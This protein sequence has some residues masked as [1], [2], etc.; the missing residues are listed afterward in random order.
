MKNMR[1]TL[2]S[3]LLLVAVLLLSISCNRTPEIELPVDGS[4]L[5]IKGIIGNYGDQT[6]VGIIEDNPDYGTTGEQ[7][8]WVDGDQIKLLL[9]PGGNL[10]ATPIV[11]VFEAQ[12]SGGARSKNCSFTSV[13][14][15][16]TIPKGS[17]TVYSLYPAGGWVDNGDGTWTVSMPANNEFAKDSYT[18]ESEGAYM[19]KKADAG[20]VVIGDGD[21][22]ITLSFTPMAAVARFNIKPN[23]SRMTRFTKLTLTAS[24]QIFPTTATLPSISATSLTVGATKT[25]SLTVDIDNAFQNT[26]GIIDIFFPILPTGNL[27]SSVDFDIELIATNFLDPI[28]YGIPSVITKIPLLA[29]GFEASSSYYFNLRHTIWSRSNIVLDDPNSKLTFAEVSADNATIPANV[30]GVFFK[31]G[32]LLAISPASLDP[33][34]TLVYHRNYVAGDYPTGHVVYNPTS[35]SSYIW[36]DVPYIDEVSAAFPSN[37]NVNRDDFAAYNSNTGFDEAAGLGDICRYITSK[38]WVSGKWRLPTAHE[39]Y[40]LAGTVNVPNGE[41]TAVAHGITSPGT[42]AYGNN[43]FGYFQYSGGRW[44][45][46]KAVTTESETNPTVGVFFFPASGYRSDGIGQGVAAN[47]RGSYWSGTSYSS[48][49]SDP[50]LTYGCELHFYHFEQH[51]AQMVRDLAIPVRCVL[52]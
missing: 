6:K 46:L 29:N 37:S 10:N 39:I 7:F 49:A 15:P 9:Y 14:A 21:N 34:T 27:S 3:S 26:D 51:L 24:S 17:Y 47:A 43:H 12:V 11:G 44:Y 32:S 31:F 20:T 48:S 25:N 8:Y 35:V 23:A 41:F 28:E 1:K 38:G 36:D 13:G 22:L 19:F 52:Q 50:L 4:G 5:V 18:S 33:N 40:L 42:T 30:Q 45:G 16:I 2:L